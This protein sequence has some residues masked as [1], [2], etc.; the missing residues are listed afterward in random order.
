LKI[1]LKAQWKVAW[2]LGI[3]K[4]IGWGW[5]NVGENRDRNQET[6]T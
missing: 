1:E 4:G 6:A 5:Q 3:C 2:L